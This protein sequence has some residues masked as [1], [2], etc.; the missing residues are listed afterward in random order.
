MSRTKADGRGTD[1]GQR[2]LGQ[3][4]NRHS[5]QGRRGLAFVLRPLSL[6]GLTFRLRRYRPEAPRRSWAA[7]LRHPRVRPSGSWWPL[8]RRRPPSALPYGSRGGLSASGRHLSEQR[9]YGLRPYGRSF[10]GPFRLCGL[11]PPSSP[12]PSARCVTSCERPAWRRLSCR[13][14]GRLSSGPGSARSF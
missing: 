1:K 4:A 8:R 6:T 9:L 12:R 13:P 11:H 10:C 3:K 7:W 5:V 14:V 2:S